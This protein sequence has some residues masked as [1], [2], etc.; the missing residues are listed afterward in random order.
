MFLR[1]EKERACQ[2]WFAPLG[3]IAGL[4]RFT[5]CCRK[6]EIFWMEA[7][8][9]TA[10]R[11]IP[12]DTQWLLARRTDGKFVLMVPIVD[13]A[14][15]F[16]LGFRDGKLHLWADSGDPEIVQSSGVGAY[17]AVGDDPYELQEAGAAAVMHR[18]RTGT[19]RR[20]K[21]MPDFVDLFGWNTWNAFYR[22]VSE[23]KVRQGLES[24][25]AGGVTPTFFILDDGWL[26]VR[27][28]PIGGDRLTRFQANEKFPR[29]LAPVVAMAKREFGVKR[30]FAWHAVMGY[31]AGIDADSL[32]EYGVCETARNDLPSFGRDLGPTLT[33]MGAVCGVIPADRLAA[34]YDAFHAHLAAQGV[35]GVK[36]DNQSSIELTTAGL[37][38]RVRMFRAYRQGLEASCRKHFAGR[39]I[40]CMSNANETHL[41]AGDSALLR[42]STDFWPLRPETHG[43]HLYTNAQVGLWFGQ[44]QHPDW[45]MFESGHAMGAYHAA[46][47]AVSGSPVYVSDKPDEHDFDVLRKLVCADGTVLRCTDVGR[48]SPDCLFHDP[49]RE[50]VL[51]K[52]FNFNA[53]GAVLGLFHAKYANGTAKSITGTVSLADVPGLPPGRYAVLAHRS[54]EVR[55]LAAGQDWPICLDPGQWEIYTLAAIQEGRAVLGLADKY[56]SGG[57]LVGLREEKGCS[58][59]RVRDGGLLVMYADRA[60]AGVT[61]GGAPTA[62]LYDAASGKA[63]VPVPAAGDVVI[64][65]GGESKR[66]I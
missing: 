19:L 6:T 24:F 5:A 64:D 25:R 53:H 1:V 39:R 30:V 17:M 50:D 23:E 60:P 59:L 63:T 7:C 65:W 20:D 3:T 10:L 29:D 42:S 15:R 55:V 13:G 45:D 8:A 52:I 32:P 35:D 57:A 40:D 37:G 44:F 38:G 16:C 46:S 47:R 21:P 26:S 34:F 11:E 22:D 51:L 62:V 2:F 61:A 18:L 48:P 14:L 28:M 56:N 9:G 41:M 33:W 31:W 58:K 49:T 4:D 43:A 27:T 66:T 12:G 36:V 54:G